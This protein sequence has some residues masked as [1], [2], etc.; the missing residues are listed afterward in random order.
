MTREQAQALGIPEI[1]EAER[2]LTMISQ[3]QIL[4]M[5]HEQWEKALR[6]QVARELDWI[7]HGR[8]K[9]LEEG[10]TEGLKEGLTEGERKGLQQGIRTLCEVLS[11]PLTPQ[12]EE[13][14]A[15]LDAAGLQALLIELR[16]THR[17]D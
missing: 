3:D 11:I 9:G 2:K 14:L 8:K 4:Q 10:L 5:Q 17:W 6:D 12:R 7:E 15:T 1:A 13:A 16:T